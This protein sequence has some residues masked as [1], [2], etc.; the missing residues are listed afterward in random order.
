MCIRDRGN[1][2]AGNRGFTRC[3]ELSHDQSVK[4]K[5]SDPGYAYQGGRT[6]YSEKLQKPGEQGCRSMP[7]ISVYV[8]PPGCAVAEGS[9][10]RFDPEND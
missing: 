8:G 5:P 9:I 2:A 7:L 10:L 6:L 4:I 1:G 3:V